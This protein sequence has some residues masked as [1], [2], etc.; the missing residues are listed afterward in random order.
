MHKLVRISFFSGIFLCLATIL[1]VIAMYFYVKP[2][3]PEIN[4]VDESELQMPMKIFTKDGVLIGEFGEIKRRT[5]KY[6]NIP[7]DIKNAFLAAED[8]NF[9]NHQGI[10]YKGLVRSLIRCLSVTGCEG[11]GGTITMQVV[12]GYLLTRDQTV[13]RKIKEIYLALELEGNMSKEEIFELYVNR[14]FLGNR[15]YGIEAA[16]NTYFDK[17]LEDLTI[18]ESATIAALAQ[19]PSRVNPVKDPRRTIQRRNWILSRMLL[20]EYIDKTQ[21]NE[22]VSQDLKIARN[23]NLYNIDA[24]HIAEIARQEVIKRYGLKAYKEGWSII[25]TIDSNSQNIAK[26]SMMNQLFDYDKR[27]GWREPI[28]YEK[29]FNIN[30]IKSLKSLNLDFLNEESY[31][32]NDDLSKDNISNILSNLFDKH[33]YYKGYQKG[34]VINVD[35][36]Q[37]SLINE[38]FELIKVNWTSEYS[39]ARKRISI[40]NYGPKPNNFKE[41][42]SFGDLIYLKENQDFFTVDQ[43]PIAESS[44]ISLNPNS[45][46]IIAY[47]GGK[48]FFESSFDRV[49]LS[50][51]QSGSSFKP[52][53]YSAALNYG[54]NLSTLINDAPIVFEDQNLESIWRPQNY[55]GD[56]YGPISLRE[57][58]TKSVN[59]VSIK[60]LRELGID[61]SHNYLENFGFKKSRLPNDLSLALGSGNFSPLEMSR[62]YSVIATNGFIPDIYFIDRIEDRFG[63][64][65]FSHNDFNIQKDINAFPW[66]D[67]LEMNIKK[68]YY[69]LDAIEEKEKVIDER[70]AFLMKDVLKGFM[71]NGV[72]GRKSAFL[73][74]DDIGGKTGTTNDS[75][76]TWFSGFHNDLVTTVWVGTDD[77]TSL[78]ENE[79]GSTISLPIWLNYMDFKLDTLEKYKDPIPDNISFVRVN[80]ATGEIDIKSNDNFYFELFLNENSN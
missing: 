74:R 80:K 28:N 6:E 10:S 17:G 35:N 61:K 7:Q 32:D 3:L 52:F 48:N 8:D 57:A 55:T 67:T 69:L 58:L 14:I 5:T 38:G 26:E 70:V 43:I 33:A 41:M 34:F 22:A 66:L 50:Y 24:N 27:H 39:W 12:R 49:R 47:L 1:I 30:Q 79:Y 71:K 18:S 64:I 44:L 37:I 20:L 4:L 16:A 13:I 60:L 78:G 29:F 15:S 36:D 2:S 63:N 31:I 21:F 19:L 62:A 73:E 53:I 68:P 9:F 54:Y 40:N 45:G 25:T 76:S 75:I 72:A 65:I 46:E 51:P 23:I 56:F 11:G 42:V 59:I 77:F